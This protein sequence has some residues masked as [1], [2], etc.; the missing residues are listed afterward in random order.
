GPVSWESHLEP[1]PWHADSTIPASEQL[2]DIQV[3][4]LPTELPQPAEEE[5]EEVL[6]S[7]DETSERPALKGDDGR[8]RS[9]TIARKQ[10]L[11]ERRKMIAQGTLPEILDY[12]RPVMRSE[13]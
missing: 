2:S 8:R 5:D 4:E 10:M 11:R 7:A 6:E 13:C 9:K 3:A 12:E 1:S